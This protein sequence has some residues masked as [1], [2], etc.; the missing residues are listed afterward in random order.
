VP[1]LELLLRIAV[2]VFMVASLAGAGAAVSARAAIA[3]LTQPR[4]V[5]RLLLASW[6]AP[7][8]FALALLRVVPIDAGYATGLLLLALAP[9]APFAPAMARAADGDAASM[10]A[11]MV[12]SAVTTV[13][14]MPL[15]VPWLGGGLSADPVAIAAPLV[16]FVLLPLAAG[17]A[18]RAVRPRAAEWMIRRLPAV[19][20]LSGGMAMLLVACLHGPGV[21]DAVG[22]YAIAIQLVFLTGITV[23][24]HMIGAPLVA[25]QRTVLTLAVCT[26][27]L[28]AALAP[29]V[30]P[31]AD[32][33]SVVMIAIGAP[34]T[35]AV[36]ALAT[37]W[38]RRG[39]RT[40]H[41]G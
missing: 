21:V 17:I 31:D 35:L 34:A 38:L 6:V 26:R 4:F 19:T 25:S 32:S 10:A 12:L 28:G 24:A 40:C 37:Q 7:P 8:V 30:S 22:S 27:N 14:V 2:V 16:C 1:S 39:S 11:C 3:P 9:C 36:S 29:L 20:G 5:I 18:A 41:A 15:A 13:L 33:R 23:A